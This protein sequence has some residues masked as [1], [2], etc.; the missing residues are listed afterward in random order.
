MKLHIQPIHTCIHQCIIPNGMQMLVL[1]N[2]WA[3][4][5]Q[6]RTIAPRAR[7]IA[8]RPSSMACTVSFKKKTKNEAGLKVQKEME[9]AD[10]DFDIFNTHRSKDWAANYQ[11][12]ELGHS[13]HGQRMCRINSLRPG[14]PWSNAQRRKCFWSRRWAVEVSLN[15]R[16]SRWLLVE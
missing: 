10:G 4:H 14:A 2:H 12:G 9:I 11:L 8:A 16:C 6:W 13:L 3:F 1:K 5:P 15:G 7:A